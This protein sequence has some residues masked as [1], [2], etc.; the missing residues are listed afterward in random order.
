M[1]KTWNATTLGN[2]IQRIRTIFRFAFENGLTEKSIRF[3]QFKKPS[4]R[5]IRIERSKQPPKLFTRDE[6]LSLLDLADVQMR[7]MILLGVNCG[8][9]NTDCSSLPIDAID[10]DTS[11]LDY[12]R[13]KTGVMRRCKL[14]PETTDAIREVLA[15]KK[16]PKLIQH[17]GLVFLTRHGNPWIRDKTNSV[18][19]QFTK[20]LKQLGIKREGVNFYSLRH[21][22]ETIGGECKDQVAV[23]AVMGHVR[24]DMASV[25][26]EKISD[27][28]LEDVAG[29]IHQWLFGMEE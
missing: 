17:D 12:P 14:W 5:T 16:R 1:A 6:I 19:L 10:I 13:P 21:M 29:T 28:R 3:G 27:E 4:N 15:N 18:T 9:G 8:L 11:W 7:A 24:N 22:T 25:Y 2:E 23:D 26:R 20:L